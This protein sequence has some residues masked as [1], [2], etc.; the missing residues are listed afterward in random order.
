MYPPGF[1]SSKLVVLAQVP[2]LV[3]FRRFGLSRISHASPQSQENGS[4]GGSKYYYY[5]SL[6]SNN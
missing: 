5:F 3:A 2:P 1:K 4:G 6:T